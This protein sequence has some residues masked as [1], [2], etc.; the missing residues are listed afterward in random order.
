MQ[1]NFCPIK[2]A[3]TQQE[4]KKDIMSI[5]CIDYEAIESLAAEGITTIAQLSC[6]YFSVGGDR[7][8]DWLSKVGVSAPSKIHSFVVQYN[9]V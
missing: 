4:F 6:K 5:D 2:M 9:R 7:F 8:C 3:M 1:F